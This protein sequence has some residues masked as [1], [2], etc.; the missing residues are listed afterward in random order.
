LLISLDEAEKQLDELVWRAE[1]GVEI[2]LMVLTRREAMIFC[3][4]RTGCQNDCAAG[5]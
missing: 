1:A 2:V 5:E 4:A 3:T